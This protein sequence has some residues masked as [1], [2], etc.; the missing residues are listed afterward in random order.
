MI[1]INH[2]FI[3]FKMKRFFGFFWL[4][5]FLTG[6]CF[7]NNEIQ[8]IAS[9][10]GDLEFIKR[11]MT[12]QYAPFDWKRDYLHWDLDWEYQRAVNHLYQKPFITIKEFQQIAKQ[13]LGSTQDYHV[14]IT[15]Y[16]T[17]SSKL[18]FSVKTVNGKCLIDW[19][20]IM[21]WPS[22]EASINVGDELIEFDGRPVQEVL[23]EIKLAKGRRA[24]TPTNQALADCTLTDRKG[25]AGDLISNQL[26]T[27]TTRT[28]D[29]NYQTN[30]LKWDYQPE[31]ITSPLNVVLAAG[32][33]MGM[34]AE[35]QPALKE[36]LSSLL[37]KHCMITPLHQ[38]MVHE[39]E[40]RPGEIGASKSFLPLLGFPTWK[41]DLNINGGQRISWFAYIYKNNE[42]KSIG[43]VRIP[44]YSG[45]NE[46]FSNFLSIIA[47]LEKHTDA[48]VIDQLNNP[49]GYVFFMYQ[50][51][52]LFSTEPMYTPKHQVAINQKQVMEAV[53]TLDELQFYLLVDNS[54]NYD[55]KQS[56][57][58]QQLMSY[59]QFIIDEWNNGQVLTHPTH[60]A[61]IECIKPHPFVHYTKP[62]LMLINELDFS[63]GDFAPAILQ[64]NR[65]AI[66]MGTKTA[67]A[68]GAVTK[69]S[70]PNRNGIKDVSFTDTIAERINL[71]KIENLGV[72]PDIEYQITE[73]DIKK[74]Y[75]NY[76]NTINQAIS[77]LLNN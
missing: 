72:I 45:E 1:F 38:Q 70:F 56:E 23:N 25:T 2:Y 59:Y 43:Y 31:K 48:L 51:L 10:V 68:G 40:L 66:L 71:Q 12:V 74:G 28:S 50:L 19:I 76:R 11:T 33:F 53:N 39:I 42:D 36:K 46:D 41:Y 65:R 18:P 9:M 5:F 61:G 47:Y 55:S 58:I 29:N 75:Q 15:F 30:Q 27:I 62:I 21:N 7:A 14:D 77:H 73:E 13:F 20:D 54:N 26:I 44:H 16:S 63:A 24:E 17:E 37:K 4:I 64:D 8:K 22:S 57:T 69:F 34:F 52:S 60:L 67:G 6:H 3:E 32:Q 49:G 35:N